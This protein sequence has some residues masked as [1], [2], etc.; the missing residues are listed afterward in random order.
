MGFFN[1]LTSSG[2]LSVDGSEL[3]KDGVVL[4]PVPLDDPLGL[5]DAGVDAFAALEHE[6]CLLV[7]NP[8]EGAALDLVLALG[9]SGLLLERDQ[10]HQLGDVFGQHFV[11]LKCRN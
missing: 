4:A 10:R 2:D 1:D 6:R 8:V 9:P 7:Q 5:A 11:N 3:V